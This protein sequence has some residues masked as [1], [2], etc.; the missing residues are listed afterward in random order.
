MAV[1]S[2]RI[3]SIY[4]KK[5][6]IR[7]TSKEW[8]AINYICKKENIP[9]KILFELIDLNRNEARCLTASIRLFVLIYY[10]NA[11]QNKYSQQLS[12]NGFVSPIFETIKEIA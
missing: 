6:S 3:I 7:L 10:K 1:I 4:N 12:Q 9:R 5:T 2:N 11:I 8:E